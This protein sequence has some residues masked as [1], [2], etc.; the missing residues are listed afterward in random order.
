MAVVGLLSIHTELALTIIY[1]HPHAIGVC[2][3]D[4]PEG[5][6]VQWR[7]LP[8]HLSNQLH[9]SNGHGAQIHMHLKRRQCS[10]ARP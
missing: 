7:S 4:L 1:R 10:E 6:I 2:S 8:A 5:T 3:N 9:Q